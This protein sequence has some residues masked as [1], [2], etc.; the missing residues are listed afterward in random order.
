MSS[1]GG[2]VGRPVPRREDARILSGR[3]QYLDDL[4]PPGVA[5]VAFTRSQ[6]AYARIGGYARRRAPRA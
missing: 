3:S 4:D 1:T 2:L 6:L 5:H